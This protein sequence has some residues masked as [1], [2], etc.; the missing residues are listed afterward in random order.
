MM[1]D[2]QKGPAA[3]GCIHVVTS[4]RTPAAAADAAEARLRPQDRMFRWGT[5]GAENPYLGL[6]AHGD[7]FVVT[8]DSLSMIIEVARLGKPVIIAEPPAKAG[9]PGAW[10]RFA[11][12]FRAR[13]LLKAVDLLHQTGH[14]S[15]LGEPLRQ[16]AEPLPD[17]TA[18]VAAALRK[19]LGV[20]VE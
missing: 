11:G 12:L 10:E 16:P 20:E 17:D 7:A 2:L 18:R 3:K 1:Q 6:L 13:D 9:L 19:L 5:A 4:R 15:R 14:V 8:A